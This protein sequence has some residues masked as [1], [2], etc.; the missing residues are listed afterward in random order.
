MSAVTLL[1]KWLVGLVDKLE[2]AADRQ[3]HRGVM[4]GNTHQRLRR[5]FPV[6]PIPRLP[7][8]VPSSLGSF[9]VS[10]SGGPAPRQVLTGESFR[11]PFRQ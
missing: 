3:Y 6:G 8:S 5:S 10:P 2:R 11:P 1:S 9:P 4:G 7:W